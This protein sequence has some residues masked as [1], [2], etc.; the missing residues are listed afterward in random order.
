MEMARNAFVYHSKQIKPFHPESCSRDPSTCAG[1]VDVYRWM[2]KDSPSGNPIYG[3]D[4]SE[5][6]EGK[7]IATR[8]RLS[9][10]QDA[11]PGRIA[12]F[13]T[14]KAA[15]LSPEP[16]DGKTKPLG[17]CY[18]APSGNASARLVLIQQDGLTGLAREP[19]GSQSQAHPGEKTLCYVN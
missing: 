11:A 5:F 9:L 6:K 2:A 14:T 19:G 8:L 17:Y 4:P 3:T 7:V 15:G 16:A 1:T 12:L 13:R 10:F 18:S